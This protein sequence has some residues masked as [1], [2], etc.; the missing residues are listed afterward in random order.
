MLLIRPEFC[1]ND[2][3]APV[4]VFETKYVAHPYNRIDLT[5]ALNKLSWIPLDI[6]ELLYID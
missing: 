5:D 6:Y 2:S 1:A 3:K 4:I